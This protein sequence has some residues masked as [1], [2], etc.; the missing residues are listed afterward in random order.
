MLLRTKRTSAATCAALAMSRAGMRFCCARCCARRRR[1]QLVHCLFV[2]RCEVPVH[3][4]CYGVDVIPEGDWFCA[5]CSKRARALL[6]RAELRKFAVFAV[7]VAEREQIRCVL[8]PVKTSKTAFKVN[9]LRVLASLII[10]AQPVGDVKA[11][12]GWVHSVRVSSVSFASYATR[13]VQ[14]CAFFIPGP[15]FENVKSLEPVVGIDKI[16]PER[17]VSLLKLT[18]TDRSCARRFCRRSSA[19]SATCMKARACSAQPPAAGFAAAR[20]ICF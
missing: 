6:Q 4:A 15:S 12:G 9:Q 10:F 20:K 16:D 7:P 2:Q 5:P 19:A 1:A 14:S 18:V 13:F 11:S 3:Q 8:C 17:R